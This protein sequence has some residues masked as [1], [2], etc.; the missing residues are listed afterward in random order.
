MIG[1]SQRR[2]KNILNVH[3]AN[4]M[5]AEVFTNRKFFDV[6]VLVE[7]IKNLKKIN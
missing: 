2:K 7:F 6:A 4:H 1:G 5:V 3:I